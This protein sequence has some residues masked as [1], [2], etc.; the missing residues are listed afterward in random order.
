[1]IKIIRPSVSE[2]FASINAKFAVSIPPTGGYFC[3]SKKHI[4]RLAVHQATSYV[5][6]TR[7]II[8]SCRECGKYTAIYAAIGGDG[9][10]GTNG[11][12]IRVL[13][14]IAYADSGSIGL[15][16]KAVDEFIK[17]QKNGVKWVYV[18]N[19]GSGVIFKQM[20]Q[21]SMIQNKLRLTKP[22]LLPP[23]LSKYQDFF[24]VKT[25]AFFRFAQA[26]MDNRVTFSPQVYFKFNEL[27]HYQVSGYRI[28]LMDN[29]KYRITAL[30]PEE[31]QDFEA[32]AEHCNNMSLHGFC[33]I[34][35]LLIPFLGE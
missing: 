28:K 1:M 15:L 12:R 19:Y 16:V 23:F 7:V 29:G 32:N 21:G 6:D 3:L 30:Q 33:F 2:P 14:V 5:T 34:E 22:M 18:P 17:N 26:L 35:M 11:T 25:L 9:Y 27:I 31:R 13:D 24:D 8:I 20:A 4:D 10:F